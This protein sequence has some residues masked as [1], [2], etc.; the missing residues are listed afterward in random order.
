MN[1][2]NNSFIEKLSFVNQWVFC[3]IANQNGKS[4]AFM[5]IIPL[6]NSNG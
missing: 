4:K 5:T 2:S 3:I 1:N 6:S